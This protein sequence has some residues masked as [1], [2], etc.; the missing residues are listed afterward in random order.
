MEC[1]FL[2]SCWR[3]VRRSM[4]YQFHSSNIFVDT[5]T[6]QNWSYQ[7]YVPSRLENIIS[8]FLPQLHSE[9]L[10]AFN[11]PLCLEKIVSEHCFP[12]YHFP[13][14]STYPFLQWHLSYENIYTDPDIWACLTA[15]SSYFRIILLPSFYAPTDFICREFML[16]YRKTNPDFPI[17]IFLYV[18]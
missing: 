11:F 12:I 9:T 13:C 18:L 14:V 8:L 3:G 17:H 16:I 10:H 4:L 2:S 7:C 6:A 5:K 15:R 1:H